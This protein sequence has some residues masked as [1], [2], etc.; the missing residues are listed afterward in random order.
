MNRWL[1]VTLKTTPNTGLLEDQVYYLGHLLGE[2]TGTSNGIF[3]VAFADITPIRSSVGQ[4]VDASS[5]SDID[6]NGTI[7]FSDISSMR[8]SVGN[9]LRQVTVP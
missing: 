9:Q 4:N 7:S 1:R 6:K 3:T 5:V 8:S 2:T